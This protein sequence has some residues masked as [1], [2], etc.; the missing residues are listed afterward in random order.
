MLTVVS[1]S[2]SRVLRSVVELKPVPLAETLD[3]YTQTTGWP[4]SAFVAL[5]GIYFQA[6]SVIAHCWLSSLVTVP[7]SMF[8]L[9]N[10]GGTGDGQ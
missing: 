9:S 6:I 2:L 5:L 4:C 8:L 1:R 7:A 10:F 3:L